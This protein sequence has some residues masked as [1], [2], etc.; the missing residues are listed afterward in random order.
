MVVSGLDSSWK[1]L[2][3]HIA[4]F[5]SLH[6]P[7]VYCRWFHGK[8]D[9][10]KSENLLQSRQD[11]QFLVRESMHFPGDY[12][13]SVFFKNKVEH[14]RIQYSQNKMTIDEESFFDNLPSLVEV[15]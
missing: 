5:L 6:A 1:L 4:L 7:V 12:T 13:L 2:F 10:K 8:I 11:G 3:C 14:Y 15:I 9:R